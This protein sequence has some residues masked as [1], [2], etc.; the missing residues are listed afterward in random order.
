MGCSRTPS[1]RSSETSPPTT[2]STLRKEDY[3]PALRT[4]SDLN[5]STNQ[6]IL[7]TTLDRIQ[8]FDIPY[9]DSDL[10]LHLVLRKELHTAILLN[11]PS[12]TLEAMSGQRFVLSETMDAETLT[13]EA[14]QLIGQ[15]HFGAAEVQNLEKKTPLP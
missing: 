3:H 2:T 9:R 7:H 15:M 4:R 12:N 5:F 6:R 14:I 11:Q 10:T 13:K 8:A 1:I